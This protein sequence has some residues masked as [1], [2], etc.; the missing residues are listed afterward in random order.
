[1]A[2][3]P[4]LTIELVPKAVWFSNVRSMISRQDWDFLRR[5]SYKKA[6]YLCEICGGIGN[7]HPVECHE[8]WQYDD[9]KH[10]QKL[11]GLISLCPLCHEVKHIGLASIRGR[12]DT[13]KRH[14]AKINAWTEQEVNEYVSKQF[15]VWMDRSLYE[16]KVDLM[17]LDEQSIKYKVDRQT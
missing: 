9:N 16:W 1:M 3:Q 8:I 17:W 14:L 7:H 4:R 10:I 12:I 5:N 2:D 6:G 13:V 15:D 11:L